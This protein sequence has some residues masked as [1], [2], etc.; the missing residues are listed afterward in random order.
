MFV[1]TS[2]D[3]TS[4]ASDFRLETVSAETGQA[5]RQSCWARAFRCPLAFGQD[6]GRAE[7]DRIGETGLPNESLRAGLPGQLR[8]VDAEGHAFRG[9]DDR[10]PLGRDAHVAVSAGVGDLHEGT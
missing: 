5:G 3:P 8:S 6:S 10:V 9:D 7:Q 2:G 1:V 4:G